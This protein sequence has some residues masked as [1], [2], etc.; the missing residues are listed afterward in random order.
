LLRSHFKTSA[1]ICADVT[2]FASDGAAL[3]L[4]SICVA[5]SWYSLPTVSGSSA[6]SCGGPCIRA[7]P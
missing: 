7:T 3:Y 6:V 5:A 4:A 2:T 1:N